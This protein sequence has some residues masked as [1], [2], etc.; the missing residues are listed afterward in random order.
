MH[1]L[2][3]RHGFNVIYSDRSVFAALP[4]LQALRRNEVVGMQ[5]DPVGPVAGRAGDRVLRPPGA[6]PARARS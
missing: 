5:I 4:V 2:R 3:T 6:V 1:R